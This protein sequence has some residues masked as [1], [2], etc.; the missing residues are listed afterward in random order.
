[1]KVVVLCGGLGTRLRE[2]TEFRP[3]P[4]VE[5]G[6]R[7]ILWHI[8]KI[9]AHAGFQE[10]VLC[11]GY[12]GNMIK[13]YFLNYEA[14]NSDF[15]ICLGRRSH[16]EYNNNHSEQ[17]FR[18]TLVDTGQATMTGGRVKRI[19]KYVDDGTFLLTYGDGVS[20]VDLQALLAFHRSHGK[21]ATVTTVVPGSRFGIVDTGNGGR[22]LKF[23]EKPRSESRASAGFFVFEKE[24]F[25]YLGSDECILE[26]EPLERLAADQQLMAYE[27]DGFFYAMDTYREYEYLNDLWSKDQAP[28][29]V[30]K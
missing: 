26:R 28:W 30:W 21:I 27:H 3:K 4:M 19:E 11:L 24:V 23:V 1:M 22:V 9:Y 25:N 13:D 10:F 18:V 16:I 6:G 7:P 14:M 20:N 29:K 17:D 8:M 12:R 2:E 15:T 5:I